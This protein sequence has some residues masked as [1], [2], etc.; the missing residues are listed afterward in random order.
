M[1]GAS[2]TT[3][4]VQPAGT[5]SFIERTGPALVVGLTALSAVFGSMSAAQLQ[6]AMY[7]KSQAAQDQAK[8]TNQWTLAGFKRDRALLMQSA[9]A[10]LR[11]QSDYQ[12]GSFTVNKTLDD[13]QRTAI[14][15]L[16]GEQGE[17][18]GPPPVALPEVTDSAIQ[19][20]RN[21]I[22]AREPETV[23]LQLAE[24]VKKDS[25]DR[26]IDEAEKA[27]ESIDNQW[28]PIIKAAATVV[29]QQAA[30]NP[31]LPEADRKKQI[32]NAMATQAAGFELE[33]RR[34]RAEA[35]LNQGIG[36]LY[37]VRVKTSTITSDQ[38]RQKSQYLGYAMLVAQLG[39]VAASL[40][41]ARK[42]AGSLWLIAAAIGL[43]ALGV[44]SYALIPTSFL[45]F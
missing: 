6:L 38:Y 18:G 13:Q 1:A 45:A 14:G 29:Q 36:L 42:A 9:S 5:R 40:A 12:L 44:G 31:V 23:L 16:T 43:L 34:Y 26:S 11:A 8:A 20:L 28:D 22:R 4:P 19:D 17:N 41:L 24:K 15:W 21:A 10:T 3:A 37:E 39:A 30:I 33:Q 25:L 2:P 32:T 35:S 27:V 7:W